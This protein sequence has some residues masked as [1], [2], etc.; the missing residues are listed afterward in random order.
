MMKFQMD[1]KSGGWRGGVG[2]TVQPST[3]TKQKS[4]PPCCPCGVVQLGRA[5]LGE[6]GSLS[7]ATICITIENRRPHPAPAALMPTV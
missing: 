1:T 4:L 6:P 3:P 5:R 2:N 7:G